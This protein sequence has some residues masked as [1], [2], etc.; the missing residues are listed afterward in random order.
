MAVGFLRLSNMPT[1][2]TRCTQCKFEGEIEKPREAALP[3]CPDCGSELK[4]VYQ[5]TAVHYAAAG[6]T[7]TDGRLE[8]LVGPRRYARFA[9]QKKD[10][11]ARA[12]QG[13]LTAYEKAVEAV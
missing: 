2:D 5:P 13:R 8:K 9:A 6:F 12:R 10:V 1:Y 4:R 7:A 3:A 11:E